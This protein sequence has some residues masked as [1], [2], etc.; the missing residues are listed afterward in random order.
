MWYSREH[1]VFQYHLTG[2]SKS[3]LQISSRRNAIYTLTIPR[4]LHFLVWQCFQTLR[5]IC[6]YSQLLNPKSRQAPKV[7][8]HISGHFLSY[9]LPLSNPP[10]YCKKENQ[11]CRAENIFGTHLLRLR[12][13][14]TQPFTK[15]SFLHPLPSLSPALQVQLLHG[16]PG[17]KICWNGLFLQFHTVTSSSEWVLL[18]REGSRATFLS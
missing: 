15:V 5:S 9:P 8:T 17:G 4:G 7:I 18:E 3:K 6:M 16:A 2:S 1:K 12:D 11:V 10:G 13:V 14:T